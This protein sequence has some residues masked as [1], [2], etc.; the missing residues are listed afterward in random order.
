[1][2]EAVLR[3][4]E[5]L[6]ERGGVLGA[7]ETGYQ[8]GRIQDESMLYETRKHDGSYPIVGVNVFRTGAPEAERPIWIPAFAGMTG[9]GAFAGMTAGSATCCGGTARRPRTA[10]A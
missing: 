1:V 8:R 3:E 10:P 9:G 2:E 7:M 4:L 6:S 5:R